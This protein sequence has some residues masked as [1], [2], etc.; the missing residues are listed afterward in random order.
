MTCTVVLVDEA[1]Q[2]VHTADEWWR[3]N[4]PSAPDLFT[5]ELQVAFELL[6]ATPDVGQR[7]HRA[8][9]PGIRRLPLRRSRYFVYYLHDPSRSIVYVLAVWGQSRGADPV[10]PTPPRGR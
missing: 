2:Q 7:F 5:D 8:T 3:A 9:L 6:E 10:L 1:E 4:R